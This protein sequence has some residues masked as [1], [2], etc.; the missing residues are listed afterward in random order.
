[1]CPTILRDQPFV[2]P[3]K[4]QM[5]VTLDWPPLHTHVPRPSTY[6]VPTISRNF[7]LSKCT[8]SLSH[9]QLQ[10]GPLLSILPGINSLERA[11]PP[12]GAGAGAVLQSTRVFPHLHS[13]LEICCGLGTG[14]H[15]P[16]HSLSPLFWLCALLQISTAQAMVTPSHSIVGSL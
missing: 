7:K 9:D 13:R 8:C 4:G 10:V 3:N 12:S 11:P 14:V 5:S 15:A 16:E 2:A 6:P 1:M